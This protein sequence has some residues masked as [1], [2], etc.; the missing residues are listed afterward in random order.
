MGAGCCVK[1]RP[2][3][4]FFLDNLQARSGSP[5]PALRQASL[6]GNFASSASASFFSFTRGAE[7]YH[8]LTRISASSQLPTPERH[9][10]LSVVSLHHHREYQ[11]LLLSSAQFEL[12]LSF[13]FSFILSFN[14]CSSAACDSLWSDTTIVTEFYRSLF[15]PLSD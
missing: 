6:A 15:N 8:R 3:F 7:C 5:C 9:T 13:I 1:L 11:L 12:I 4:R 10:T 2:P 14:F